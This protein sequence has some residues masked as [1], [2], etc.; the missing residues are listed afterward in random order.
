M[1]GLKEFGKWVAITQVTPEE[2]AQKKIDDHNKFQAM[3]LCPSCDNLRIKF[4]KL[5]FGTARSIMCFNVHC[6]NV[7]SFGPIS[8]YCSNDKETCEKHKNSESE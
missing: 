7:Y 1:D 4:N 8:M 2:I 5:G 3:K 6:E